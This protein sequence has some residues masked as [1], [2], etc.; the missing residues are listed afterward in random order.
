M[1]NRIVMICL[2]IIAA[3]MFSRSVWLIQLF[4]LA[5]IILSSNNRNRA[6]GFFMLIGAAITICVVPGLSEALNER[7]QSG[8][9]RSEMLALALDEFNANIF[10]GNLEGGHISLAYDQEKSVH[11]VPLALALET[12]ILGFLLSIIISAAFFLSAVTR[13]YYLLAWKVDEPNKLIVVI[14][15]SSIL[16]MRPMVSASFDIYFS[17]GEWCALA[18]FFAFANKTRWSSSKC[19]S[20]MFHVGREVRSAPSPSNLMCP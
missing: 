20:S 12:G 3:M 19:G 5:L 1:I 4:F 14:L 7:L 8:L 10:M 11:N 17:I 18:I 2:M 16:F 15:V 6:L 9:G 13:F